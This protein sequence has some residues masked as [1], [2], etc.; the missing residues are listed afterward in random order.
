MFDIGT[1]KYKLVSSDTPDNKRSIVLREQ[2][3]TS[4]ETRDKIVNL[5]DD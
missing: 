1:T 2:K 4:E 5:E 3:L